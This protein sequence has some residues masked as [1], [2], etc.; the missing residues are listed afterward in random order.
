MEHDYESR[1]NENDNGKSEAGSRRVKDRMCR[2]LSEM[3]L[4]GYGSK[5]EVTYSVKYRIGGEHEV[6]ITGEERET[7]KTHNLDVFW[8][9]KRGKIF[10][11]SENIYFGS[12]AAESMA[13]MEAMK[14]EDKGKFIE[15]EREFW[16]ESQ[17]YQIKRDVLREEW[18]EK[19]K[20]GKSFW[21]K[22]WLHNPYYELSSGDISGGDGGD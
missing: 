11:G 9:K 20:R 2:R 10:F 6:T 21:A 16:R 17:D 3:K 22:L 15:K 19:N 14:R 18:D 7:L 8:L 5:G 13:R 1:C 4:V 12:E